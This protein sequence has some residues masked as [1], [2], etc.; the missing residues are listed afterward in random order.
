MVLTHKYYDGKIPAATQLTA[1]DKEALD[2]L[3]K[4]PKVLETSLERFRFREASQELMNLARVGNKYL[5]DQEP[6]KLIKTDPVRVKT[7]MNT[8]LQIA[9]GLALL[10]EPF[11]P[12]TANKLQQMLVL[13][14]AQGDNDSKN[15]KSETKCHAEFISASSPVSKPLLPAGHTIGPASLLFT[16][17]EDAQIEA[18]LKKLQDS[19]TANAAAVTAVPQKPNIPFEDFSKMDLRIGTIVAAE[20]IPKTKKLLVLQVDIGTETR[21]IVSGIAEFYSPDTIIGQKVTVLCN[22]KPRALRGVES[23]GMLLMA[24]AN[25]GQLVFVQPDTNHTAPSGMVVG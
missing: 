1:A 2:T 7:I 4:T 22:L 3:Q 19:K 8:A 12:F 16:K 14:Q 5:A 17:I 18:Q 23:Q 10:S 11:L 24:K 25:D 6:W 20:K 9:A 15:F 21:T 13:K